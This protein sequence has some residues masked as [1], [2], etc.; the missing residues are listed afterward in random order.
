MYA[1]GSTRLKMV[2]SLLLEASDLYES[3]QNSAHDP[4]PTSVPTSHSHSRFAP[5]KTD[6]EV[7]RARDSRI[8]D[9]TRQDTKFCVNVWKAWRAY[10]QETAK[11]QIPSIETMTTT[12]MNNWLSH[13]ALEV[14]KKNGQENPPNSLHHICAGLQR[15]LCENGKQIDLFSGPDFSPFQA[16]LDGEMKRL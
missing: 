3:S 6:K 2:D 1:S 11:Q 12:E 13:F 15:H 10:R 5:P 7:Q 16:T 9:K 14:R 8:P 4:A